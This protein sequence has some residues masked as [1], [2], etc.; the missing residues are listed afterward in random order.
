MYRLTL[1]GIKP[2]DIQNILKEQTG[3]GGF[4]NLLRKIK[5]QYSVQRN[6]LWIDKEDIVRLCRYAK[7]Y[8]QGGFQDRIQVL[9][10]KLNIIKDD[11]RE[12]L[13]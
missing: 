13:G 6:E 7:E 2:E 4:Q 8:G 3:Q 12:I 5:S 11:L 10:E 9:L 1:Y